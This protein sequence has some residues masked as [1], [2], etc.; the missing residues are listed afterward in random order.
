MLQGLSYARL[1][2]FSKADHEMAEAQ[3]LCDLWH[4]ILAAEVARASGS[5]ELKRG[6]LTAA[7]GSYRKSLQ[8]ARR[9]SNRP[10]EATDLMNLSVVAMAEGHWDESADWSNA[11]VR[12]VPTKG[13]LAVNPASDALAA[14]IGMG[15]LT[16][17]GGVTVFA[18]VIVGDATTGTFG[19]FPENCVTC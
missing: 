3:R 13:L 2:D 10:V 12:S 19:K 18:A 11:C 17:Y 5:L 8:L 16:L 15:V 6:N 1:G 7:E 9:Q 4:S 14:T